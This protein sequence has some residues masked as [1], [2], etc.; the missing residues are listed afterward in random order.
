MG[1]A[2]R[3]QD[4]F[5]FIDTHDNDPDVCWEWTGALGGRDGRGYFTVAGTKYLAHRLV[6]MIFYG[7]ILPGQVIRHKCDNPKCCNPYHLES[8]SRSDN[9]LDKYRRGRV[10]YPPNVLKEM[11]R[12]FKR[13][14]M[15]SYKEIKDH[16]DQLFDIDISVSGIAHVFRNERRTKG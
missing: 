8:G 2:N 15:P 4:V 11:K 16:L 14:P 13:K 12:M 7:D 9:E 5:Q 6:Y 3:P 10:G 1:R